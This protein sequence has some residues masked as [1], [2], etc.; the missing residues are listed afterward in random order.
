MTPEKPPKPTPQELRVARQ[1]RRT[2]R[3]RDLAD[4]LG[5]PEAALVAAH[6]G[7]AITR[8][9]PAPGPI[10]DEVAS[11]GPLM[12]LT[13]NA[14]CVIEHSGRYGAA[15]DVELDEAAAAFAFA[16]IERRKAS[17]QL[18]DAAGDAVHK[19]H[20]DDVP[21]GFSG[22]V[23]AL[24]HDDQADE[25]A[26][27]PRQAVLAL[28]PPPAARALPPAFATPL[29]ERLAASGLPVGIT[30]ANAATRQRYHGAVANVVAT[31]P[32]IN[33]LD[34]G[35]NLHLREDRIAHAWQAGD[36]VT[37]VAE[38]GSPVV[39]FTLPQDLDLGAAAA[40]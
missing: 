5:V 26:L 33:V 7:P 8:L 35:F 19:I 1:R 39:A 9:R 34:P 40:G 15:I 11:L 24:R 25:L 38:D 13:R 21:A 2:A 37:A 22:L 18:Y 20:F 4:A 28:V 27:A 6:V 14:H 32:W 23:D 16:Q 12:G 30:V 17:V 31:G 10:F 36:T 29:L 3:P